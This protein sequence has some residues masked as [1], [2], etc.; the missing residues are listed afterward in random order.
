M[1]KFFLLFF[2][3]LTSY[4]AISQRVFLCDSIFIDE[5]LIFQSNCEY[6]YD[7]YQDRIDSILIRSN[8]EDSAILKKLKIFAPINT[9]GKLDGR[10]YGLDGKDTLFTVDYKNG[11]ASGYF[12]RY[13]DRDTMSLT[14][15]QFG[16]KNGEQFY[17]S[18]HDVPIYITQVFGNNIPTGPLIEKQAGRILYIC[19]FKDG[20]KHGVECEFFESGELAWARVNKNGKLLDGCYPRFSIEGEVIEVLTFKNSRLKK[21]IRYENGKQIREIK[22]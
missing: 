5:S 10:I 18:R 2:W 7:Y 13:F 15:L 21:A 1:N 14:S 6:F 20:V 3:V 22:H 9:L 17:K 11:L 4:N 19:N 12:I 8:E 16:K